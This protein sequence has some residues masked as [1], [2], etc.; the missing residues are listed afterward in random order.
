MSNPLVGRDRELAELAQAL[1]AAADQ[2]GG[3]LLLLAGEAG[4]GKSRLA[5]E[6]LARSGL[7]V[8][9][10][11]ALE[12][13]TPP[14]GPVVQALRA[15]W[16]AGAEPPEPGPLASHLAL[17]LPELGPA[18]ETSDRP[19]LVEALCAGFEA[20]GRR[21]PAVVLI[22][23]LQWADDATLELLPALAA[24]LEHARVLLLA[25]YRSDEIP[26]GHGLRRM[27]TQL[28]R[29]GRFRELA[30]EPLDAEGT[31]ALAAAVL[32]EEPD[33][34]LAAALY[35]RT[36]GLPFFVEELAAAAAVGRLQDEATPIPE[37]VR[38]AILLR[39][40]GLAG[41]TLAALEVAAACGVRFDLDLVAEVSG[42]DLTE[43]FERGLVAAEDGE[44]AFRHALT[45][46]TFYG[47]IPLPRRRELHRT[48]A[49]RLE[50]DGAPP[51]VLAEHWVAAR[52]GERARPALLAAAEAFCAVHAYRDAADAGRK[53]LELW[54]DQGED[55][56]R[57]A[58]LDR[59][60]H[61][62][63]LSGELDEAAR[64]WREVADARLAAGELEQLAEARRRLAL[65]YELQGARVRATEAREQ[66]AEGFLAAGL[67]AEAAAEWLGAADLLHEACEFSAALVPTARAAAAAE[68]AGRRD[69]AVRAL[70]FEG[71]ERAKLGELEHGLE[72]ARRALAESLSEGLTA[73]APETYWDLAAVL[74]L[75]ADYADAQATLEEAVDFCNA[76]GAEPMEQVCLGCLVK[77]LHKTGEWD[78]ALELGA[79]VRDSPVAPAFAKAQA[80]A[81]L[82][83]I[84]AER[85][86]RKR[87][88][89]L[90]LE[91]RRFLE[92][93]DFPAVEMEVVPGLAR[94]DELDGS[95]EAAA[96]RC[97]SLRERAARTADAHNYV[98]P[99]R[100]ATTLHAV[101]GQAADA[102]ACA[103]VLARIAAEHRQPE[104]LAGLAHAL[105]E[106]ALLDGDPQAAVT[107]FEQALELLREA[108]LPFDR[109]QI[110]VRAGVALAAA[111]EREPAILRLVSAYRCFRKLGARFC[112]AQTA[113]ELQRLG[114]PVERRLGRRAAA[115]LEQGGL[116]RRELDVLRLVAV[117]RT[118]RE[119]A[120]ELFLSPRTVDMHVRNL[121][122]KLDCRSRTEATAKAHALGLLDT[123]GAR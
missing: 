45:R 44:A 63:Q 110:E 120:T 28:R 113:A 98:A 72:L 20:I 96:E 40:E 112:A 17:L 35:D 42:G 101:E 90:L 19:T 67:P 61:C 25:T 121:L 41:S 117:G 56:E 84:L 10:G 4:V 105:G 103:H 1:A 118:N 22:E 6:A 26:R 46:E 91:A 115:E 62:A 88:R 50:R 111:G 65:T 68:Q 59:L 102:R 80:A 78:R 75:S 31:A 85:G 66:A 18:A 51:A 64:C 114:E 108:A 81:T 104:S 36:Q 116:T 5:Q 107:H 29:A 74:V 55:E 58:V 49:E 33:R 27:R 76:N 53:A 9:R 79:A 71:V 14:Y 32:G 12:H 97:R 73:A 94:L 82:G 86:E 11:E 21:S 106:T 54:P 60:G 92:D 2:G 122:G 87:A 8:F 16:R 7:D 109:A 52:D 83:A 43:A 34:R 95:A 70:G 123:L 37:T 15:A 99:L 47:E 69:L 93:V 119:I 13:A 100:Y 30:L 23:D 57:L 89:P 3:G 24:R 48:L 77:V 39:A 38:E